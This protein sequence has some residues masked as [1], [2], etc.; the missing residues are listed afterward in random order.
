MDATV[1]AERIAKSRPDAITNLNIEEKDLIVR[2]LQYAAEI[3]KLRADIDE[4]RKIRDGCERIMLGRK[5]E[6]ERLR[7][8]RE[9]QPIKTAPRDGTIIY[10]ESW[11]SGQRG[12]IY[13]NSEGEWELVNGM[14]NLPMGIG[15][16]PT[17]WM[18]VP[19]LPSPEDK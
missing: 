3:E 1:L 13:F 15:F 2:A 11:K 12:L 8:E 16:Y 17:N 5:A 19:E 14:N 4:L 18:H 9:W 10:G 6:I 7:A